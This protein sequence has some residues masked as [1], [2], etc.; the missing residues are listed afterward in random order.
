MLTI[1][2]SRL[3]DVWLYAW[4]PL[5]HIFG[6]TGAQYASLVVHNNTTGNSKFPKTYIFHKY[7]FQYLTLP[8]SYSNSMQVSSV[9]ATAVLDLYTV[10]GDHCRCITRHMINYPL[11]ISNVENTFL[12]NISCV[13]LWIKHRLSIPKKKSITK[14]KI[15]V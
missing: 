15:C 4:C 5:S 8:L 9:L 14:G 3:V 1:K 10:S 12:F 7:V 2:P 6:I 11:N 13:W